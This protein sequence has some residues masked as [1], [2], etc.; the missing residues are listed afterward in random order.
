M[1]DMRCEDP[2]PDPAGLTHAQAVERLRAVGPNVLPAAGRKGLLRIGWDALTQPMFLLLL[3][4]AGVYAVLGD[5]RDAAMLLLS[6]LLVGALSIYQEHRTERV[7]H[8][9]KDLSSPRCMVVREGRTVRIASRELVPGDRLVVNEGDRLAADAR[10]LQANGVLVDESQ[11][12]GESVPVAKSA[13]AADGLR[14]LHAG[15]L[16]VQGDGV[17]LV[18][19]TGASTAL[20]RIGGSLA[21]IKVR[22]SRLQDELKWLVQRVA[23]LAM[24]TC[25]FAATIFAWREGS[26]TAG[27]LVGLTLAM[28]LIP[29][30]FAVVWTVMLALGAWRLARTQ[31]LTRQPQAIEALGTT[32]VLCVDKTGTLTRNQMAL[33]ALNDGEASA[34]LAPGSV[35][36]E[37]FHG[38]LAGAMQASMADGIEPMDRAI[39]ESAGTARFAPGDEWTAQDRRGVREGHPW[40]V[41]WWR[42]AH[43]TVLRVSVK[44]APEA[45]LARCDADAALLQQLGEVAGQWSAAGLRV[46]AVAEAFTDAKGAEAA[47]PEGLRLAPLGLLG[48]MDPLRDEVPQAIEECRQAGVRVIMITG[49]SPRTAQAIARQ[50]GLVA[51]VAAPVVV[52]GAE[53]APMGDAPLR[54]CLQ[55]VSVF[56]RMDPAQKLRIVHALQDA[57]EVV[58]MTGD[59]VNDAP[60]LRA[61]DI[62]VAM[63]LRG[64]DV[65]REAAS[66]VLLD[67]N[68]ASL[69]EAVRA[70]RRIFINLRKALGYLFAVH[71]PIVGV[72]LIPVV[73][74]GPA[75]LL[76]LH[77]V[78]LELLIDP[79]CSLVF[80]AQSAPPD[81]MRAPPRSK[82]TRLFTV[83]AALRAFAL[84]GVAF[85]GVALVQWLLHLQDASAQNLR[86]ASL[87][88]IVVGNLLLL[89]WFRGGWRG[90]ANENR[91]FHGLLLGVCTFAAL[92]LGVP[93]LGTPLGFPSLHGTWMLAVVLPGMWAGW[94]LLRSRGHPG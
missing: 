57:G 79:A 22:R 55:R 86:L 19:A 12:T 24:M 72:A 8:A 47:L 91:P 13:G 11:L 27:L 30:E 78:L 46:L 90:D 29:E 41:H 87:S 68:F 45:V 4:T 6:V 48:F 25:M 43:G 42:Q 56:A 76:P 31:V 36:P 10:L 51:G 52:T 7:L 40:V 34:R 83:A 2:T 77:V 60:A 85:A 18:T 89:A 35:A 32:T 33:V 23:M 5:M 93:G 16:V 17:A 94:R 39:F 63:G 58:A 74:G 59:G 49:D 88:S 54:E 80:E 71:V 1:T 81:S 20:G 61:A 28:S 62:G 21:H 14:M 53:L 75:L 44:G 82:D 3:A 84:G 66:L 26:W 37:R 15:S 9:L 70:G 65:A 69:V 64:T 38:L 92:V 67:D 73:M 50:A